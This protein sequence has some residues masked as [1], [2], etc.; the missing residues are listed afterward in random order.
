M[1]IF[2]LYT[3]TLK[4]R[5]LKLYV[6]AKKYTLD[7]TIEPLSASA[8]H[9]HTPNYTWPL[10]IIKSNLK[11][12]RVATNEDIRTYMTP[13]ICGNSQR[14]IL[15]ILYGKHPWDKHTQ[16]KENTWHFCCPFPSNTG[17]IREILLI[18]WQLNLGVNYL[19]SLLWPLKSYLNTYA[20][21][22]CPSEH[23][24]PLRDLGI[25]VL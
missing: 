21:S 4:L 3:K 24:N 10:K 14:S 8:I 18:T 22:L 1:T 2:P 11:R 13:V 12:L 19:S 23:E 7:R 20:L 5:K 15:K 6:K 16:G 25:P 9:R 17:A